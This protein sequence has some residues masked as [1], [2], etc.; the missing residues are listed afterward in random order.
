MA[1]AAQLL[2]QQ[3]CCT[4]YAATGA[5]ALWGLVS[6]QLARLQCLHL[7]KQWRGEGAA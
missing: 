5:A 1:Q 4:T 3:A 7:L 6:R 2:A